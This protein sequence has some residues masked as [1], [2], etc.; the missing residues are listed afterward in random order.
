[1]ND[2]HSILCRPLL[3]EKSNRLKEESN[4][5]V[6]EVQSKANKHQ[7]KRAVETLFQVKVTDVRTMRF[8]GKRG[9]NRYGWSKKPNWKKAIVT[10]KEGS[11][12]ELVE[13]L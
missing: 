12:I 1:M 7:V 3:T 6:F 4:Q 9:R 5:V 11:R 8:R 13:G 10:L 2:M